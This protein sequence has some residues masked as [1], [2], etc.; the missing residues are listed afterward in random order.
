MLV[1]SNSPYVMVIDAGSGCARALIWDSK[2]SLLGLAQEEWEYDVVPGLSNALSFNTK[3]GWEKISRCIRAVIEKSGVDPKQ[4]AAVSTT[5]QREGFVLYDGS[6]NE[7]WA[8]PNMDARASEEGSKIIEEG[9][10][11]TLYRTGGDWTSITAPA[12]LRWIKNH[13][14]DIWNRTRHLTMLGDWV[15]Q[16]LTGE[17]VA[18]ASLASSS[19]LF[20]LAERTWSDELIKFFDLPGIFPSVSESGT[21]IGEVTA[22][23]SQETGLPIGTPCVA[24]GADT[25]LGLIGAGVTNPLSFGLVGGSYWLAAAVCGEPL[26]DP[27]IRL[28]TLCHTTPD[29]WMI[30]GVGFMHGFSTRW[31]RD[32]FLLA[33]NPGI[34]SE[35]GY[36]VLEQMAMEVPPGSNGL[37]YFLSSV[38][39]AKQW[40]MGPPSITGFNIL[41][42]RS[43][44]LGGLFRAVQEEAAYGARGHFELLEEICGV[45][46]QEICFVGGPSRG[47]LWPQIVADVIGVPVH[48]PPV[49]EATCLG[50]ALYACVAIGTYQ[51]INEAVEAV[52]K[53]SRVFEPASSHKDIYDEMYGKWRNT[54]DYLLAGADQGVMGHFWKGAGS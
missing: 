38:M 50:T 13:R 48:V 35:K 45:R 1:N 7:I 42:P 46:P 53:P 41:D 40:K 21:I 36:E 52:R 23:A 14:P 47:N 29:A 4:I 19:G 27:K 18:S 31:I 2:G 12:R 10:A 34:P 24:G 44:G 33:A 54:Y 9:Q 49:L 37:M 26:T 16:K 20:S 28:R 15:L 51:H 32:G 17:F 30:E 39:N 3:E 25:Q 11:E 22:K 5:S 43:T 6:G 8:C